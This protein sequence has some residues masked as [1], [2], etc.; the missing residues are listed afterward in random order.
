[1]IKLM[2]LLQEVISPK[3]SI[4]LTVNPVGQA[5]VRE[6]IEVLWVCTK[7]FKVSNK[8]LTSFLLINITENNHV[9]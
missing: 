5:S 1:M 6:V 8:F 3:N 2:M 4:I 7:H 9:C